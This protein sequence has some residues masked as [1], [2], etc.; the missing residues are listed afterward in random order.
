[1]ST[2]FYDHLLSLEEIE[3]I[4]N[5][6]SESIEEKSELWQIVDDTVHHHIL[7][8]I[9][10]NLPRQHHEEFL[11]L[12]YDKPYDTELVEYLNAKISTPLETLIQQENDRLIDLI[13]KDI[14]RD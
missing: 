14:E 4:I 13:L 11:Q 8:V 10:D 1:M 2:I 5:A 7:M 3:K 12:F 9:L 6:S